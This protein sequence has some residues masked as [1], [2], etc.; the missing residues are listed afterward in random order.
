L[1][2]KDCKPGTETMDLIKD[3]TLSIRIKQ[4]RKE[5]RDMIENTDSISTDSSTS[6]QDS[7]CGEL[8]KL[9]LAMFKSRDTTK[10]E[11][12]NRLGNSIEYP[13]LSNLITLEATQ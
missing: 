10:E 8:L 3:G 13:I 6:D 2:D 11:D 5:L 7:Q 1:K 12:D 9:T 4:R